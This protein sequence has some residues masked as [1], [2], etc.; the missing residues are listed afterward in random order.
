MFKVWQSSVITIHGKLIPEKKVRVSV[1][2]YVDP[3]SGIQVE[4]MLGDHW[5]WWLW[6]KHGITVEQH[7]DDN[8]TCENQR[9][10]LDIEY[11]ETYLKDYSGKPISARKALRKLYSL[12]KNGIGFVTIPTSQ[13]ELA[14][15]II[16]HVMGRKCDIKTRTSKTRVLIK[17]Y[18]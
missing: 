16:L 7:D 8:L 3:E 17:L 11:K 12:N 5:I 15:K 9:C 4:T 14:R 10:N 2:L 1:P 6:N 13:L 18:Y